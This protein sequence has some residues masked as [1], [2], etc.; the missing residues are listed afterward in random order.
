MIRVT[1]MGVYTLSEDE[2]RPSLR[3]LFPA[4]LCFVTLQTHPAAPLLSD[5][6]QEGRHNELVLYHA[7]ALYNSLFVMTF[8]K[9]YVILIAKGMLVVKQVSEPLYYEMKNEILS[10]IKK[11]REENDCIESEILFTETGLVQQYNVSRT[12]VRKAVD[13][14]IYDG[15]L[16]RVPGKG[17]KL[18]TKPTAISKS[19]ANRLNKRKKLAFVLYFRQNDHVF[20]DMF[21]GLSQ[22]ANEYGYSYNLYNLADRSIEDIIGQLRLHE[23]DGVLLAYNSNDISNGM[24]LKMLDSGMPILFLDNIPYGDRFCDYTFHSVLSDDFKGGFLCACALLMKGHQHV[25]YIVEKAIQYTQL[26][27]F[28]GFKSA[29][30]NIADSDVKQFAFE[31]S[32]IDELP[33]FLRQNPECTAIGC[34]SDGY[35]VDCYRVLDKMGMEYPKEISLVGYNDIDY[36]LTQKVPVTTVRQPFFEMGKAGVQM[37]VEY[38]ENGVPLQSKVFSVEFVERDSIAAAKKSG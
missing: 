29:Y 1:G 4:S 11:K 10:L 28:R 16:E 3:I 24:M 19:G 32:I 20:S 14:L 25:I 23:V 30:E 17:I 9:I 22:S 13:D 8:V 34:P 38:L 27:R 35:V 33:E 36:S 21:L 26:M 37:M 6:K 12:T 2:M 31:K 7:V 18:F 5:E 15:V